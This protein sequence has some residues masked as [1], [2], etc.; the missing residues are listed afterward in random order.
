LPALVLALAGCATAA[1]Q[2]AAVQPPAD[3]PRPTTDAAFAAGSG[4]ARVTLTA[5]LYDAPGARVPLIVTVQN[6]PLQLSTDSL[7]ASASDGS[8][9]GDCGATWRNPNRQTISRTCYLIAPA[10]PTRIQLIG[11]AHWRADGSTHSLDSP[12][13]RFRSSGATS[14]AVSPAQAAQ[15][16]SCGNS[17][18]DVWLTFDDFVPSV[19]VARSLVDVLGRN[20]ARGRFFLNHI[21][22]EVRR[23]LEGAG[24]IVEDHTRDH[25]AMTD[26]TDSQIHEQI[27]GGPHPTAGAPLLL[28]PPY[29]AGAEAA[30][31]VGLIAKDGYATCRWTVDSRDWAGLTPEQMAEAVRYGNGYTPPVERGGVILMHANHFTPE[32]LQAVVDAVH[33]RGLRLDPGDNG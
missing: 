11:H 10:G 14:T 25:L 13:T 16:E 30:R 19:A 21:S 18:P 1:G 15:I 31:V 9:V 12:P 33:A 29:G 27:V 2:A 20:H 3:P 6:P 28:R 23:I 17:G 8:P 32:K 5:P 22:P 24:H 4:L 26:L 7:T